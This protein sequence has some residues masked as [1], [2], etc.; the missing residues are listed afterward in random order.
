MLWIKVA[1]IVILIKIDVVNTWSLTVCVYLREVDGEDG[2][3][4]AAGVVHAR[5]GRG[6]VDVARLHQLLHVVVVLHQVLGQ[7]WGQ[8]GLT[9]EFIIQRDIH[10]YNELGSH[11]SALQTGVGSVSE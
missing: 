8:I 7:V 5:G 9:H 1:Y 3:R 11:H 6:A 4:A 2:V 10:C